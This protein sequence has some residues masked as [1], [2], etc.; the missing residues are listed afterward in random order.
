MEHT[1]LHPCTTEK[2]LKR[3]S[4]TIN[5][6]EN[7]LLRTPASLENEIVEE[8]RDGIVWDVGRGKLLR[9]VLRGAV[10]EAEVAVGGGE[11]VGVGLGVD[12]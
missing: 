7:P 6:V 12:A 8:G 10:G 9:G 3:H 4:P 1:P 5:L 11:G 2:P